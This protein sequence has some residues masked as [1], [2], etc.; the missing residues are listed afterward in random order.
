MAYSMIYYMSDLSCYCLW[1]RIG[2]CVALRWFD[3]MLMTHMFM[4]RGHI[5]FLCA[6]Q[7]NI[8]RGYSWFYLLGRSQDW[9][10][11]GPKVANVSAGGMPPGI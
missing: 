9:S 2:N 8:E 4:Y 7:L 11:G 6:G 3:I 10:R 5:L 1:T